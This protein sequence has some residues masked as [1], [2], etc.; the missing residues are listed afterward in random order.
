MIPNIPSQGTT[1]Y[2]G[3]YTG[4]YADCPTAMTKIRALDKVECPQTLGDLSESRSV[5]ETKCLSS[6]ESVKALGAISRQSMTIDM[7]LD[8]KN[9][10]GQKVLRESFKN[11]SELIVGVEIGKNTIEYFTSNVSSAGTGLSPDGAV[12]YKVVLE[13]SSAIT[14]CHH[15]PAHTTTHNVVHNGKNI[16]HG[17]NNVV[18]G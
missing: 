2:V 17:S 16:V 7:L 9:V 10:K 14:R 3:A 8:P 5:N 13:I 6:N 18:I 4:P 12:T 15:V 1:V 11:N